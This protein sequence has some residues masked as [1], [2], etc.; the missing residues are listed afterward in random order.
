MKSVNREVIIPFQAAYALLRDAAERDRTTARRTALTEIVWHE[1]FLS[2]EN[3][4]ERV[5]QRLGA[6]CFGE[7]AW[8]DTFNRD[9][10][11]VKEAFDT[12]SKRLAFSRTKGLAG[13]YL[14]GEGRLHA[15]VEQTIAHS[16]VQIDARQ[17]LIYRSLGGVQRVRQALRITDQ[18]RW[19]KRY[20]RGRRDSSAENLT[21]AQFLKTVLQV[22]QNAGL[23]Y[24]LGGT[25]AAWV[26][27]EP[28]PLQQL[29]IWLMPANEQMKKLAECIHTAGFILSGMAELQEEARNRRPARMQALLPDADLRVEFVIPPDGDEFYFQALRSAVQMDYG[30]ETGSVYILSGEFVILQALLEYSLQHTEESLRRIA[31]VVLHQR[32]KI[33]IAFIRMQAQQKGWQRIWEGVLQQIKHSKPDDWVISG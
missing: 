30:R 25:A 22:L 15:E 20:A 10:Q 19:E 9:M 26:W 24:A 8:E 11:A 23:G 4:M 29:E 6:G 27:G 1:R 7:S 21:T 33:D 2:R 31:A 32:E 28:R 16:I 17:L 12:C 14:R 18:E 13:Y 3:L 5:E